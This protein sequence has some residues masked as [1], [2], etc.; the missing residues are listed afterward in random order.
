[1]VRNLLQLIARDG[2]SDFLQQLQTHSAMGE[3]FEG[4]CGDG[5]LFTTEEAL[6]AFLKANLGV[7][8]TGDLGKIKDEVDKEKLGEIFA[9]CFQ[10]IDVFLHDC[11]FHVIENRPVNDARER[12]HS[13]G[14][15]VAEHYP[16]TVAMMKSLYQQGKLS[17]AI[18]KQNKGQVRD[19]FQQLLC[20]ANWFGV[21]GQEHSEKSI[22]E[23]L[24][25]MKQAM[26]QKLIGNMAKL[27]GI[28]PQVLQEKLQ[29]LID[30]INAAKFANENVRKAQARIKDILG[31]ISVA[32]DELKQDHASVDFSPLGL[33][34]VAKD[35]Q[36]LAEDTMLAS[37]LVQAILVAIKAQIRP[38]DEVSLGHLA[39]VESGEVRVSEFLIDHPDLF[40]DPSELSNHIRDLLQRACGEERCSRPLGI[41]YPSILGMRYQTPLADNIALTYKIERMQCQFSTGMPVLQQVMTK[42]QASKL[43]PGK[44]EHLAHGAETDAYLGGFGVDSR[45]I[46]RFGEPIKPCAVLTEAALARYVDAMTAKQYIL[47]NPDFS[48]EEKAEAAAISPIGEMLLAL[49]QQI[50]NLADTGAE[51]QT[52]LEEAARNLESTEAG[53]RHYTKAQKAYLKARCA[54]EDYESG[55]MRQQLQGML[56]YQL[57]LCHHHS[58]S[59]DDASRAIAVFNIKSFH[60]QP[61]E[62]NTPWSKSERLAKDKRISAAI[63]T[64]EA[65]PTAAHLI[66]YIRE[67]CYQRGMIHQAMFRYTRYDADTTTAKAL[68]NFIQGN[69]YLRDMLNAATTHVDEEAVQ[70]HEPVKDTF[71]RICQVINDSKGKATSEQII[72]S[73]SGTASH[74][75]FQETR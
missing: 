46:Q 64:F 23:E 31:K 60:N 65:E 45:L 42:Q 56:Q 59:N 11:Q 61:C 74:C 47:A 22:V 39:Q 19:K 5:G 49:Q 15:F 27:R 30:E 1:M 67:T 66:D 21:D 38:E 63:R 53:S 58:V 43:V 29:P 9:L 13:T 51:L 25:K 75:Q 34:D 35:R 50:D 62:I 72:E 70:V 73:L 14:I 33:K 26:S 37:P 10:G 69:T 57:T 4:L 32:I 55:A 41:F 52:R 48:P 17:P 44:L 71:K 8:G 20:M 7:I 36:Y 68:I 40:E 24:N 28:A 6:I 54:Y 12:P 3:V 18:E 16:K 2:G